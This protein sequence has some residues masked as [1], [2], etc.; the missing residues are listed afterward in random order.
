MIWL[1]LIAAQPFDF[2]VYRFERGNVEVWYQL[3][4]SYVVDTMDYRV[5]DDTIALTFTYQLRIN[6]EDGTDSA[7]LEG[8]KSA[9]VNREE[10]GDFIVDYLPVHLYPGR[11]LFT[12][13]IYAQTGDFHAE[14]AIEIQPETGFL[15]GSD[16]VL[17]RGGFSQFL[18]HDFPMIPSIVTEFGVHNRLLVYLELYDLVPDSLYYLAQYRIYDQTDAILLSEKKKVLKF[19]YAQVDTHLIDLS[20]LVPGLYRYSIEIVDSS[21]SASVTRSIAFTITADEGIVYRELYDDIQYMVSSSEY[22]KFQKL[23]EIQREVYLKE[24]WH[25]HDYGL[26]ARRIAES[27]ERF[28]AG[29]VLGRDSERGRLYVLLGPPDE[30]ENIPIENWA[31]PF[32]VWHYYGKNDFLFSDIKNDQN[33]RLIKVLKPGELTRILASGMREGTRDEAWLSEIAPGTYDWYEDKTKPE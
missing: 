3:P 8:R 19:D 5:A 12:F 1:L 29:S 15:F 14:G 31:R 4:I 32:E 24:F 6:N 9:S 28:S 18:Y 26:F 27:D 2:A 23:S 11:F 10:Q 33:P 30:I 22:R 21:S 20:R 25:R 16:V 13:D 7:N 17:G